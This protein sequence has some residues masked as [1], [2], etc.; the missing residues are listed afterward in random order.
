MNLTTQKNII[1]FLI[2]SINIAI[3]VFTIIYK[4]YWYIFICI[5]GLGS[6]INSINVLLIIFNK[7]KQLIKQLLEHHDSYDVNDVND[8][9]HIYVLPCYNETEQELRNTID[10]IKSQTN[11][12]SKLLIIVC[13]GKLPSSK[14]KSTTHTKPITT[15][16]IL[17]D[18]IFKDFI[19]YSNT[20]TDA[21]KIWSSEWNNLETYTGT[22]QNL[23]FIILVKNDNIGK[24]D[25]LTLVRRIVYYYNLNLED[26][27]LDTLDTLDNPTEKFNYI[28]YYNYFSTEF[29]DFIDSSFDNEKINYIIGT[30]ADTILDTNCSKELIKAIENADKNTIG[31]V[32]FVD[33]I[34]TWN[35]LV[36]YQYCEYLYAQCLKRYVQS[37]ITNK[38]SCLSG[39]VQLIKVCK[40]T[41]SNAILDE[42]NRLPHE[43]ENIFNHI[44]SYA[45]EDRNHICIMFSMFPYV[46]TIQNMKAI[47][48]TN[49][50]NTFIKFLRQRKRW[51]AGANCN[52]LLLI[53]NEKHNKWERFQSLVN[54]ITFV[55][56]LFIFVA[57]IE[58][59]I[60][61]INTPTYLMLL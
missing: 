3:S 18:I 6:F 9:K 26:N 53:A 24:R 55:L 54:I 1:L 16:Q 2:L 46:K 51:C 33:I 28:D 57:T 37:T 34:K 27:T 10:S 47:S 45:S 15:N 5:L 21:Y 56:T 32:G 4:Q 59:I 36:V 41:C 40:E 31:V 13:D 20:F 49:V 38:V 42:F 61:I 11:I 7:V 12:K 23:R 43:N 39:C 44:R 48:Y 58:F 17:T 52:D 29:I 25:S 30:D 60:S 35:P 14:V 50:P 8:N 19:T 22:M